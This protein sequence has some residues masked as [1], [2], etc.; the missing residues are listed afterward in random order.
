MAVL[1]FFDTN[2]HQSDSASSQSDHT[3]HSAL[4]SVKNV[5]K[6]NKHS[7]ATVGVEVWE[8]GAVQVWMEQNEDDEDTLLLLIPYRR[9]P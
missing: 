3:M 2:H 5:E 9:A 6:V 4:E 7:W 1:L 8:H